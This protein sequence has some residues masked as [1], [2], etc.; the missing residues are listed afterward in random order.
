MVAPSLALNH[1]KDFTANIPALTT[2]QFA[3]H[4]KHVKLKLLPVTAELPGQE[5]ITFSHAPL[6]YFAL[7]LLTP[8][9]SIP[10][11]VPR[12]RAAMPKTDNGPGP[13]AGADVGQ[14]HDA[15]RPLVKVRIL[16][17]DISDKEPQ[18][19]CLPLIR[20]VW[21]R[22]VQFGPD[23]GHACRAEPPLRHVRY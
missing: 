22:W 21:P 12:I 2:T 7:D 15:T 13:R 8:K 20:T 10:P 11:I 23:M 6:S 19:G 14:P 1:P 4:M 17:S 9:G 16:P 18:S 5:P 3:H